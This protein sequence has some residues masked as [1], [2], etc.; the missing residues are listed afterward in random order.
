M[1]LMQQPAV[2]AE[3]KSEDV[4]KSAFFGFVN[5]LTAGTLAARGQS[6][7]GHTIPS[8]HPIKP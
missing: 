2:L 4:P 5:Q 6:Y 8:L 3:A 1:G 7:G